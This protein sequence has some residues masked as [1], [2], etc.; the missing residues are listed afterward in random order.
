MSKQRRWPPIESNDPRFK[1]WYI[2]PAALAAAYPVA[3]DGDWAIVGT[4]DT[5][6]IWD[7]DLGAWDDSGSGGVP[8]P[9]KTSHENTGLDEI[10]VAGLSGLLAD[11]QTPAAHA[12]S[13]KGGG[14]DVIDDATIALSGL[15]SAAD[16]TKLLSA[17][18]LTGV[19][20]DADNARLK[21]LADP[22]DALDATNK[23][24]VVAAIGTATGGATYD[25]SAPCLATLLEGDKATNMV[26]GFTPANSGYV[27]VTVNGHIVEVGDLLSGDGY[28]SGDGGTTARARSTVIAGDTFHWHG[29]IANYQLAITDVIMFIYDK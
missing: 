4:T 25:E 13:H 27:R 10:S 24:W 14:G 26:M 21:N 15:M 18:T 11:A 3:Q 23:Q 9:H 8:S 22:I 7:S 12:L 5:V 16:K 2:N 1:G 19:Y 28:F 6:W 20:Y 17:L 29:S